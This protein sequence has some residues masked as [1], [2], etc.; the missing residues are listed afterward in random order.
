MKRLGEFQ[1]KAQTQDL[2]RQQLREAIDDANT[3]INAFDT[4]N[5]ELIVQVEQE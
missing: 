2:K 1:L 3:K 5:A 4:A